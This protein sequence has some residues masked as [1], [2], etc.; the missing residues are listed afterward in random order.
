MSQS[1]QRAGRREF[2]ATTHATSYSHIS[3]LSSDLSGRRVLITGAA[4]E[5]G[6]GYATAL[7]FARAGASFIALADLHE[8]SPPLISQLTAPATEAGRSERL[9]ITG[10][11][12]ISKLESAA[13]FQETVSKAFGSHLDILINKAAHQEPY[14]SILDS[15][16][17]IYWRSV[18]ILVRLRRR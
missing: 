16:P 17:E 3:P 18:S 7:A 11:V 10:I 8:I 15:G 2:T 4:W 6:V 13:A 12:D 5:D 1:N 14:A 9:I